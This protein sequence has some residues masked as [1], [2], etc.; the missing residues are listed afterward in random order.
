M[1]EPDIAGCSG[2]WDVPGLST[3]ASMTPGC[4]RQAGNDGMNAAGIGCSVEDLCAEGWAVCVSSAEVAMK[5]ATG[6]C[7]ASGPTGMWATRQGG[8][9]GNEECQD[10][11]PDDITGCGYALGLPAG[12]TCAPLNRVLHHPACTS[13]IN[14]DCADQATYVTTEQEIVTKPGIGQGG[15]L[16]C[17]Q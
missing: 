14:W 15:V 4:N 8:M 3:P 5:A 9:A 2:A 7:P 12:L 10:G 1:G 17:R 6:M 13:A 16:C 11:D